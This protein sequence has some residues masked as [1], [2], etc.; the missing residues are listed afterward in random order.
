MFSYSLDQCVCPGGV[1]T[2]IDA[3]DCPNYWSSIER[4][5]FAYSTE[6]TTL[7]TA[8]ATVTTWTDRLALTA[9]DPDKIVITPKFGLMNFI[10]EGGEAITVVA[11]SRGINNILN[12]NNTSFKGMF[13]NLPA[14][15]E[16]E[17]RK[18]SCIANLRVYFITVKNEILALNESATEVRGFDLF[19]NT[20]SLITA[21]QGDGSNGA[22]VRNNEFS[23]TLTDKLWSEAV[24]TT[25]TTFAT[26]F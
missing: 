9:S 5:M 24:F 7:K 2:P 3:N 22:F 11:N 6:A 15:I 10:P 13:L 12:Y 20:L 19:P 25:K 1:F 14:I 4:L 17:I 26:T 8:V 23:F 16:A 21:R 18:M